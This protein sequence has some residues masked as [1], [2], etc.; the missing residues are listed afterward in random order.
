LFCSLVPRI[1]C[2]NSGENREDGSACGLFFHDRY[3]RSFVDCGLFH[4]TAQSRQR[5]HDTRAGSDNLVDQFARTFDSGREQQRNEP[6]QQ[7]N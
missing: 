7:Y 6:Q 2:S 1:L 5:N 3:D 4:A